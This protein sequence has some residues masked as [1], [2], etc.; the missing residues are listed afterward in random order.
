MS[1]ADWAVGP[2]ATEGGV[3]LDPFAG[4]GILCKAASK[5]GMEAVGFEQ[6]GD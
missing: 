5:A 4:A 6:R 1:V 2:Y 3:M